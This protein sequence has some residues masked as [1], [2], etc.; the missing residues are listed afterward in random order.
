MS[1]QIK[2]AFS[3]GSLAGGVPQSKEKVPQK[4]DLILRQFVLILGQCH[5]S[6]WTTRGSVL[7][8]DNQGHE[9]P[10]AAP[11][12]LRTVEGCLIVGVQGPSGGP[13][14]HGPRGGPGVQGPSGG[15]RVQGPRGGP[16]VLGVWLPEV[17]G[18]WGDLDPDPD[19][20]PDPVHHL[21]PGLWGQSAPKSREN[22]PNRRLHPGTL[23]P[24]QKT[25]FAKC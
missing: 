22:G 21:L 18:G 23:F 7:Q 4:G 17:W 16:G 8:M 6:R 1:F 9:L 20:D 12:W 14:V 5:V 25:A 10:G 2:A 24:N 19:P 11:L 15:P 13:G 3:S